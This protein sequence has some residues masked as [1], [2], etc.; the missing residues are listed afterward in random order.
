MPTVGLQRGREIDLIGRDFQH[1]NAPGRERLERQHRHADIAA[2]LRVAAGAF[3]E[4]R[5]QRGGGRF[6][7]GAGDG[8][9]RTIAAGLRALAAEQ[10]DVADDLDIGLVGERRRPM[11]RRMRQRHAGRQ[12]QRGDVRPVEFAQ[13]LRLEA[14]GL[15]LG[16]LLVVV[17][18]GD[19][20]G[21][22]LHQRARRQQ[23]GT[24]EAEDRDLSSGERGDRDHLNFS[25]ASPASAS[26]TATIQNRITI[27][28]SVQPSCS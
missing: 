16:D 23:A 2:H 15:R 18:E 10:F 27:C 20:L 7:V 13:I 3:D 22:A 28:G 4:M 5:D 14:G 17:V 12:H 8:D 19:D 9:Q 1:I 6:A 24:A 11:R 21:A 25:V 26:T